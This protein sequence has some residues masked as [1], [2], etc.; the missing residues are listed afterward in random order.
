M[1]HAP[2]TTRDK[3]GPPGETVCKGTKGGEA[4]GSIMKLR[5]R[6]NARQSN[7]EPTLPESTQG[8]IEPTKW[9]IKSQQ[10]ESHHA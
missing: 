8:Y 4:K 2:A 6:N 1:R 9:P 7:G 10:Y 5:R 3:A